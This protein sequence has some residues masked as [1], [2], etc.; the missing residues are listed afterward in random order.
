MYKTIIKKGDSI[1]MEN[2]VKKLF[3]VL[4][5][6]LLMAIMLFSLT[7]CTTGEEKRI[8]CGKC[9]GS[10]VYRD[11]YDYKVCPR[12]NGKGYFIQQY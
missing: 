12:C 9:H 11:G 1:F 8:T 5:I 10:G 4:I 6:V 7:A 3:I 2:S